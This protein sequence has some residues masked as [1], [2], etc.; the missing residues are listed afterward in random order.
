MKQ[1]PEQK[2]SP[3]RAL[4]RASLLPWLPAP[5]GVSLAEH[6]RRE[7]NANAIL[8]A[9]Q[10]SDVQ[11]LDP[12]DCCFDESGKSLIA[13]EGGSFYV[14]S[15]HLCP[16][17]AERLLRRLFEPSIAEI[18]DCGCGHSAS[19]TVAHHSQPP[20]GGDSKAANSRLADRPRADV[21]GR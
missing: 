10:A 12:V 18:A 1:V 14:D 4:V 2:E 19:Q 15:H 16:N 7:A 21:V 3:P 17:G 13:G 6:R 8:D 9:F 5:Q 20:S 11:I